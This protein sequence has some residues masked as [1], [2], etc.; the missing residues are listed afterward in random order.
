MTWAAAESEVFYF[1]HIAYGL[2]Y[3]NAVFSV[4]MFFCLVF[5]EVLALE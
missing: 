5:H 4:R 1:L 3:E 2:L